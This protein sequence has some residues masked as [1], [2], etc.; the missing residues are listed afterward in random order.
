MDGLSP[1][2][3]AKHN[4]V[5]EIRNILLLLSLERG[6][7]GYTNIEIA[8]LKAKLL[9]MEKLIFEQDR[10]IDILESKL[11]DVINK[12]NQMPCI[13]SSPNQ[14]AEPIP[15]QPS[16]NQIPDSDI[17]KSLSESI[18]EATIAA[19][20]PFTE[21]QDMFEEKTNVQFKALEEQLTSLVQI[22]RLQARP[23]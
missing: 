13:E 12:S 4:W 17:L 23:P 10:K 8:D 15:I 5:S 19:L 1:N 7:G 3:I 14:N 20:V 21:R 6:K 16:P 2:N 11:N 9:A 22:L 18:R